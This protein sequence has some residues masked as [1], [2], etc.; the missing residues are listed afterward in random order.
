[1]NT[2]RGTASTA[3]IFFLFIFTGP[4]PAAEP[5]HWS[6]AEGTER[7]GSLDAAYALCA[8]GVSQSP[9]DVIGAN[10]RPRDLPQM[11][12]DYARSATLDTFNNGHTIQSSPIGTGNTLSIGRKS[13]QLVQFH[14]HVPSENFLD[15]EQYPLELHFVHR[16]GDGSLA[17]VGVF[18]DEGAADAQL[19]KVIAAMSAQEGVH[20]MVSGFNLRAL[21]PSGR[22]YRFQ[23]SLTTPPCS[24]GVAWHVMGTRKSASLQQ[25]AA[26]ANLFSGIEFPGGN[27]RPVQSLNG[28]PVLTE[29]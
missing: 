3:L 19:Q 21:M 7:W 4:A 27:R 22:S 17:V 25:L 5:A 15:G 18:F 2:R 28:R 1:M 23:G 13:Y 12:F 8:S 20:A 29:D 14:L 24:E 10:A 11:N 26:F 6:Y 9:V 16:A